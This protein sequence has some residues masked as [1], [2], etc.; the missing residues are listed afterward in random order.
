MPEKQQ[1]CCYTE[2]PF[3][4]WI[5]R[6]CRQVSFHHFLVIAT[7]PCFQNDIF[8]RFMDTDCRTPTQRVLS[9]QSH[10]RHY[11]FSFAF[12]FVISQQ[13]SKTSRTKIPYIHSSKINARFQRLCRNLHSTR[14]F[15]YLFKLSVEGIQ[16][17]DKAISFRQKCATH[18]TWIPL[19]PEKSSRNTF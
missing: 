6:I 9:P 7:S 19:L 2:Q 11:R 18:S 16:K 13:M 1:K 17:G 15:F 14:N 12:T 10:S 4:Q 3:Q 8:C 5:Q